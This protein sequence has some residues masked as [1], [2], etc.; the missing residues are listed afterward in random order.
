LLNA[1]AAAEITAGNVLVVA[2]NP[3]AVKC[4][5]LLPSLQ[6]LG[7]VQFARQLTDRDAD[8]VGCGG[9]AAKGTLDSV[10]TCYH[11]AIATA[12]PAGARFAG[13]AWSDETDGKFDCVGYKNVPIKALVGGAWARLYPQEQR[14]QMASGPGP[15][16][17]QFTPSTTLAGSYK[18]PPVANPT[19]TPCKMPFWRPWCEP[20][21][22]VSRVHV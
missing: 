6:K 15:Q 16:Y 8:W 12:V 21:A 22:V 20:V 17:C 14:V 2:D 11:E 10:L 7:P 9:T 3:N 19:A 13:I 4:K 5:N 18:S 1:Y